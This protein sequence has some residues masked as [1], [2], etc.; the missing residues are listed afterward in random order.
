VAGTSTG[1]YFALSCFYDRVDNAT[2]TAL[3]EFGDFEVRGNLDCYNEVHKVA[4]SPALKNLTDSP[5]SN[6]SCSVH[7]AFSA[8]PQTGV[9]GFQALAIAQDIL[10]LGSQK[11]ADGTM[12]LPYIISRGATPVGCGNGIWEPQFEEECDGGKNNGVAGD[13]CSSSCKCLSGNPD[14]KGGCL[15][16]G[17]GGNSNKTAVIAAGVIVPIVAIMALV[18]AFYWWKYIKGGKGAPKAG[19][20]EPLS[21]PE[22][23][24]ESTSSPPPIKPG[25]T[26]PDSQ[27]DHKDDPDC[28]CSEP[29]DDE[30]NPTQ[31]TAQNPHDKHKRFKH[32]HKKNHDDR[33]HHHLNRL[34]LCYNVKCPLNDNLH[35]CQ[36]PNMPCVC[37]DKRC[38]LNE[39]EHECKDDQQKC[40]CTDQECPVN[41][42]KKKERRRKAVQGVALT[43]VKVGFSVAISHVT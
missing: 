35:M 23:P 27:P 39:K 21:D 41:K 10:G 1:L 11:F 4:D 8:Y 31:N 38:T 2:V 43:G 5:L 9:G 13:P 14:G 25:N 29:S 40:T 12:G 7:E 22:K 34:H 3:S 28:S 36:D 6:W 30:A 37:E 17:G 16:G 15:S 33:H 24:F 26:H 18:G 32:K 42:K 19:G 20:R